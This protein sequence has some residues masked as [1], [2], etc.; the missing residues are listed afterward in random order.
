VWPRGK[1]L[2][3]STVL[4]AM[5]YIRGHK[6][7]YDNWAAEGN[8]GWDYAS[9]LP[10]FKRSENVQIDDLRNSSYHSVQGPLP[11]SHFQEFPQIFQAN[12]YL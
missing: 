7:D 9:V 11:V 2:G 1:V 8:L 6:N 12:K 3:G 4:N 5:I 10:Y